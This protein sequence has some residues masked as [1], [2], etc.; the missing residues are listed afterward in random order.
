MGVGEAGLPALSGRRELSL[1]WEVGFHPGAV[2][3]PA[4]CRVCLPFRLL[5]FSPGQ[6][7]LLFFSRVLES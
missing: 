7:L 1:L 5:S 6:S 2:A 4:V 3:A